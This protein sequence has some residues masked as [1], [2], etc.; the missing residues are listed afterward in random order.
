MAPERQLEPEALGDHIDQL[1]RAAR[2]MYDSP[3]EAE[4]LVQETFARLLRKPRILRSED[5]L[6]YLH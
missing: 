6:G 1:Y 3:D 2:S 4:D 5:D